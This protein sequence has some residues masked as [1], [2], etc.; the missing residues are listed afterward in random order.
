MNGFIDNEL[1]YKKQFTVS[2]DD[3]GLCDTVVGKKVIFIG[4]VKPCE[5]IFQLVLMAKKALILE[6]EEFNGQIAPGI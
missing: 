3:Y 4:Y 6:F 2:D 1:E 5:D